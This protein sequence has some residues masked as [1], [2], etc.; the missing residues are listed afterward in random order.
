MENVPGLANLDDGLLLQEL[1]KEFRSIGYTQLEYKVLNA[2]NYG[3]PQLRKRLIIIGNRTGHIIPWPK[4]KFFE[5]PHDWQKPYRT[6]GE[7]IMDL[8]TSKSYEKFSCHVPMNH[9]PLLVERYKLI[10]EGKKLDVSKLPD[11]M[12]QG[13]RTDDVKN[14]SHVFKR[15]SRKKPSTTMVPGHNAFPIHPTLNR[16]L[17]VREAARIQTFPDELE[18]QGSRQEQCIQVGNA[19]P[20]LLAEILANSIRKAEVNKW[21]PGQVPPSA[22]YSLLERPQE[23][24]D[25]NELILEEYES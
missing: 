4:K 21:F 6:V 10:E 1:L 3:V 22:W 17:T 25:I 24:N 16:A 15:L 18:F 9:K 11:N 14:Y 8:S 23:Q 5:K 19:F 13:Y 2:A 7:V 12:K 20:P